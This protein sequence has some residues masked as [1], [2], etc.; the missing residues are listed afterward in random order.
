MEDTEVSNNNNV[1]SSVQA[2]ALVVRVLTGRLL[3]EGRRSQRACVK[4]KIGDV[5]KYLSIQPTQGDVLA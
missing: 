1:E 2:R 5:G 3:Q 4:L